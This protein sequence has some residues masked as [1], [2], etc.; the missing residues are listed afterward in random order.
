VNI[1]SGNLSRKHTFNSCVRMS[2]RRLEI[3]GSLRS[4][5]ISLEI[6]FPLSL[7]SARTNSQNTLID[8]LM[9]SCNLPL[10]IGSSSP[11]LLSSKN[12]IHM[13]EKKLASHSRFAMR[14]K[15]SFYKFL[16]IGLSLTHF[17]KID[18]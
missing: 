9:I 10:A 17:Y 15:K 8:S 13:R 14:K 1:K 4:L 5:P 2:T 12:H 11:P 16:K 18:L 3:T 7:L 6:T